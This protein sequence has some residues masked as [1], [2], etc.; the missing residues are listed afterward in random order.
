MMSHCLTIEPPLY[1]VREDL[2]RCLLYENGP[3]KPLA[4]ALPAPVGS[5]E[6]AERLSDRSVAEPG[7]RTSQ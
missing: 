5:Q 6:L 3:P 4:A 2:V 7:E 1:D